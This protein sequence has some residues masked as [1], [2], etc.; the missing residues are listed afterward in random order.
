MTE[1][2]ART[3]K[4][5]CQAYGIGRS[6][7]YELMSAGALTAVKAGTRT[8]ILEESAKAWLDSLTRKSTHIKNRNS[9]AKRR[10]RAHVAAN[11]ND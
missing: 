6:K 11:Q 8:L 1:P 3:V 9:G 5:F 7:T 4:D 10:T 2:I